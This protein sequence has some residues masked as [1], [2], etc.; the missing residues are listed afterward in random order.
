MRHN[1]AN[2]LHK[3]AAKIDVDPSDLRGRT[4]Q[5]VQEAELLDASG[6]YKRHQVYARLIKEFPLAAKREIAFCIEE[7]VRDYI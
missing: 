3:I 2:T 7:T 5:L 4:V 6:E 1:I